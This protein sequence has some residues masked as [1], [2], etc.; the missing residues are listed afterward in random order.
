ML[1]SVGCGAFP[2]EDKAQATW[3]YCGVSP[4]FSATERVTAVSLFIFSV[5]SCGVMPIELPDQLR[6]GPVVVIRST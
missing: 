5:T 4:I 6:N 1:Q 3:P 2:G